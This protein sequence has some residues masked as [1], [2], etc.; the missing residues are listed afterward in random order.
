MKWI[1]L[2]GVA[3][4]LSGCCFQSA[5]LCQEYASATVVEPFMVYPYNNGPINVTTTTIDYY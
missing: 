3:V 1:I 2:L 4:L 5:I